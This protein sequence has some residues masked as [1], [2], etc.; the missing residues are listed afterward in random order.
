MN[1]LAQIHRSCSRGSKD[2]Q[3]QHAYSLLHQSLSSLILKAVERPNFCPS[4]R[5]KRF[6]KLRKLTIM[7]F[8]LFLLCLPR[9][10]TRLHSSNSG[11]VQSQ[12]FQKQSLTVGQGSARAARM[13]SLCRLCFQI[14]RDCFRRGSEKLLY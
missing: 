14:H 2:I 3:R 13:S 10:A 4:S 11:K 1:L 7:S 8:L 9:D 12:V 6:L 5:A